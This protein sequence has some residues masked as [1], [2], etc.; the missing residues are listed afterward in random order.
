[1]EN[2]RI[3]GAY[4]VLETLKRL[5]VENIFGYPGG[6]IIPIYNEI[7]D[8]DGGIHHVFV[9]HE[10]GAAHAADGYARVSGKIGV[11]LATSGPGATNLVTGIMTAKMDSIPMLAITGQVNSTLLGKDAF[12]E[13]DIV[14]IT[15]PITKHSFL[16]TKTEDIPF[17]IKMAYHIAMSG[18]KGPV[19]VDIPKDLQMQTITWD[20]YEEAFAKLPKEEPVQKEEFIIGDKEMLTTMLKEA[21]RPIIMAGAGVVCD[22]CTKELL[23]FVEQ[24]DV[25]VANTLLGLGSIPLDN[26]HALGM[27]G[28]HGSVYG[29]YALRDADL[30]IAIGMRFDDRVTGNPE[31][32]IK[33][34]KIIH[35]D[36]DRSEVNKNKMVD[37]G[38]IT[39]AKVGLTLLKECAPTTKHSEWI[40][41]IDQWKK[42]YPLVPEKNPDGLT[43]G[44]VIK[45][46]S[47]TTE[48]KAI[49]LTD[50]GQHQMWVAQHYKFTQP[51]FF[52]SSGGAGT[53]GY[54][55]PAAMGAQ[56][57]K[58]QEKVVLFVGDGGFQMTAQELMTITQEKLPVKIIIINNG[59]LGMVRQWQELF[60][61]NRLS[62]VDL[63]L[64]PNFEKLAESYGV[65]ALRVSSA[66]DFAAFAEAINSDEAVVINVLVAK[67]ENVFPMIPAGKS[68][69]EL[70]KG[71]G[72]DA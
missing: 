67:E 53:M 64:N 62:F 16:V 68:V 12:Q 46:V 70:V 20:Q 52:C 4:A 5:G 23:N 39:N 14:G 49:V 37:V 47:D 50:V 58:P 60:H 43:A 2:T 63:S 57:A 17:C 69:E 35:I 9:R 24:Y 6:S 10:Q 21:K 65:N 1:M 56:I 66:D 13:S 71:G 59:F 44:E 25:P 27:I 40:A 34:S 3:T 33:K 19:L 32:F 26:N 42:E 38:I 31:A 29:N 36:I 11:C 22:D 8:F 7:F 55:I 15:M 51:R 18:R 48:G 54:G 61:N 30:V 28:M 41:E 72:Q 45:F